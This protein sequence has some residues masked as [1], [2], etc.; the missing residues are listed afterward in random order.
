[1]P[2]PKLWS[3]LEDAGDVT[4]PQLGT[5]GAE[6]GSPT[7]EAA[8]FNNG[9]LG[10]V[11]DE[12]CRFPTYANSINLNK[13][14]I[15]FWGKMNWAPDSSL[16]HFLFEFVDYSDGGI[17]MY[18]W[19]DTATLYTNVY[20]DGGLVVITT[21]EGLSWNIGD[22]LHFAVTWD[23]AGNDIGG[24]KTLLTK[25][26]DVEVASSTDVWDTDSVDPYLFVGMRKIGTSFS[27]VVIDNL[28][29]YDICKTDFSDRDTEG[30][31]KAVKTLIQATLI[32]AIPL[33]AIPTL[34]EILKLTG[35]V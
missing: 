20:E 31:E 19:K 29:T 35:A 3:K 30:E 12:G 26:N 27:D 22:L 8:K 4:S 9:I 16:T 18:F 32:S 24:G 17:Q 23:R 25:I 21:A 11:N 28:K 33:I 5:G 10:N 7:Y 15:E 6:V 1:M 34:G 14:A 13:G 2:M